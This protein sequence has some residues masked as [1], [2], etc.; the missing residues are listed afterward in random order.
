MEDI[1]YANHPVRQ[2][3]PHFGDDPGAID[4]VVNG[5][6]RESAP[7]VGSFTGAQS[8]Q[9]I[10]TT[11]RQSWVRFTAFEVGFELKSRVIASDEDLEWLDSATRGTLSSGR[12]A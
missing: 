8:I 3:R 4:G 9:R 6:H 7:S 10:V 2:Q 12:K 1:L 5:P 11:S